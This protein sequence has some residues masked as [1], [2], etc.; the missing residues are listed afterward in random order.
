MEVRSPCLRIRPVTRMR[1]DVAFYVHCLF[2]SA[3]YEVA[4]DLE[5]GSNNTKHENIL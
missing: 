2:C 4:L 1:H 3:V 5:F